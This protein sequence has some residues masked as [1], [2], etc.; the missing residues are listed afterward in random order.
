MIRIALLP[1]DGVGEEVLDGPARLLRR[2]ADRG[3]LEVTGP[4]PI[5][6]R[7]AASFGSV[8]PPETLASCDD[9]DALLLGAVGEDAG[10]PPEM[11][12][13]PEI[14]LHQ[15]RERYDLRISV[16][17]I[18]VDEHSDLTVVRNLIGGSYGGVADRTFSTDGSEAVDILRLTPERV[19]EVV[20][21]GYD[22]VEQ[23]GGGR[24]VSVDKANLYA[25]GQLWRQTA[26]KVAR[27]RGLPV[28]HRYVDRAA[29]ELGS[30]APV[31][32]VMVTEGLLGDILSDLAAGRAGS[33]A[34][35]GSASIHPGEPARGRCQGLFEPAHGSAPRRA[36]RN[37]VNPLGGFLA[38]VALLQHF[39]ETREFGARLRTATNTVL[40][41]GPWTYDLLA[42][43]G[44]PAPTSEVSDAVLAAFDSGHETE[45]GTGG[46][47]PAGVKAVEVVEEPAI[48]VPAGVLESWTVGVLKAVGVRSTHARD[49]ARVLAYAD[50]S[51]IDSHG[52]AR[53]PAYVR[54]LTSGI[55]AVDGEPSMH[56][57]GG[58][59]ALVDGRGLLGHPVT[60][61]AL[62]EAVDRARQYGV[63]WVNVRGSSHHGASGAYAFEA[64]QL[65]L[66]GLIATDTGPVVAPTGA[67]VPYLG[68]NPL[69]VGVPVAGEDPFVF[70]MAT[71]A[72]SAGKFE[73]ALRAG[74]SVPL[75]WGLDPEGRPTTDPARVFPDKGALLPLG[76][77]RE[78]SS[79]KGYGL[80]LLVEILTAVLAQGPTGPGVGNLT[81]R[82]GGTPP[83]VSHLVVVLDPARL[84]DPDGQRAGARRLL[85]GLRALTPIDDALPVRTPGQRAAAERVLRRKKGVPLDAETHRALL[86]LAEQVGRPLGTP[87]RG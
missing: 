71:S 81:F 3:V 37:Q 67:A 43:G 14:A 18:P 62:A 12:P 80:A 73:I 19:A 49:T 28:E 75:G 6:A 51:G 29:F 83:D 20:H 56:S 78:R 7:A 35:C 9:A 47:A 36:G 33:P 39:D 41:L 22:I 58:A 42:E 72:V 46:T 11:C 66:V 65:G 4:W 86:A 21:L 44:A 34:L 17:E 45:S 59:V 27:A 60:R 26:E 87:V 77:D 40:R 74:K 76:S 55:I 25:T 31:P 30:G 61:L 52:I 2:L 82:A 69:A 54:A 15:L 23:R 85:A 64:A 53:L 8:L 63:G 1:G 84:G 5:G 79:H 32:D 70:D 48:R 68:T 57:D 16:R 10:V 50:L 38:L 13:R 24:L